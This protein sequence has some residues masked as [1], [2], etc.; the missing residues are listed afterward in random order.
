MS[1]ITRRFFGAAVL[2]A[3]A[4]FLLGVSGCGGGGSDNDDPAPPTADSFISRATEGSFSDDA[5]ILATREASGAFVP[6]DVARAF[7]A[8]LSRIRSAYPGVTDVHARPAFVPKNLLLIVKSSAPFIDKWDNS[9]S[10]ASG[11]TDTD[12]ITGERALD[13]LLLKYDAARTTRAADAQGGRRYVLQFAAALNMAAVRD[14]FAA[15]SANFISVDT[16]LLAGDGDNI[17]FRVDNGSKVYAFSQGF[18]DCPA[19]CINRYTRTYT[20]APNGGIS[21]QTTGTPPPAG[22]GV[23]GL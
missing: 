5:K 22:G 7:D 11:V 6:L 16:N 18:G 15:S 8:D 10:A 20:I 17:V 19:G 9:A 2:S 4:V 14:E 21:E 12:L 23:T 3:G 1:K 13:A